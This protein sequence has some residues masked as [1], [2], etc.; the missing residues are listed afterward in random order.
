[1]SPCSHCCPLCHRRCPLRQGQSRCSRSLCPLTIHTQSIHNPT[2]SRARE[3]R[4]KENRNKI[5]KMKQ[6]TLPLAL[7]LP[8]TKKCT[9]KTP[10]KP[11]RLTNHSAPEPCLP[12]IAPPRPSSNFPLISFPTG[13]CWRSPSLTL[14]GPVLAWLPFALGPSLIKQALCFPLLEPPRLVTPIA[15]F[16]GAPK[17]PD[18]RGASEL[19]L[20]PYS[21]L[22]L[23]LVH[24]A[25]VRVRV[26]VLVQLCCCSYLLYTVKRAWG[27]GDG[28][29]GHTT[30]GTTGTCNTHECADN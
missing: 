9:P 14:A 19:G 3:E 28:E 23:I 8:T 10:H 25:L 7:P 2:P 20:R 21:H 24:S 27:A 4:K 5:I 11:S 15:R 30:Q 22:L 1:M 17:S 18:W 13:A 12:D 29:M 26:L 16:P 6:V